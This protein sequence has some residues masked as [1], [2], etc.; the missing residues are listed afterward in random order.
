MQ[1]SSGGAGHHEESDTVSLTLDA[2]CSTTQSQREVRWC[3]LFN[4]MSN[5]TFP[6]QVVMTKYRSTAYCN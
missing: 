4:E 3:R 5:L 6:L 1:T 2:Q